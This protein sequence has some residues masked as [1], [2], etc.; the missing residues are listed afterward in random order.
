MKFRMNIEVLEEYKLIQFHD[1]Q[2]PLYNLLQ[3]HSEYIA[4]FI[5]SLLTYLR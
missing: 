1:K 5:F 2:G 4:I 3:S